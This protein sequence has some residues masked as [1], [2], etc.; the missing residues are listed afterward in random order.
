MQAEVRID[1]DEMSVERRV[2]DFRQREPIAD[3]RLA[4]AFVFVGDN[5]RGVEQQGLGK[6]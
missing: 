1:A 6:A 5:V 4:K 2:M 3:D